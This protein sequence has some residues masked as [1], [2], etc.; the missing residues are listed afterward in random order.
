MLCARLLRAGGEQGRLG[1]WADGAVDGLGRGYGWLL[2]KAF[3]HRLITVLAAAGA[4]GLA[5]FFAG[6]LSSEFL[7]TVDRSQFIVFFE[8]PEGSTLRATKQQEEE[9]QELLKGRDD[10]KHFFSIIG[11]SRGAGP[12][13]VNEGVAFVRLVGRDQRKAHQS[14]IAQQV[15]EQLEQIPF[16]RAYVVESGGTAMG[17]GA[18]IKLVL[19]HP[20]LDVLA[21]RQE[22]LMAWMRKSNLYTGVNSNLKLN[23]PQVDVRPIRDKANDMGVT[24]RAINDAYR[25]LLAE[26]D[27]SEIERGRERYEVIPEIVMRGRMVPEMLGGVY[28][29]TNEGKLVSAGDLID[30]QEGVGPSAV[31]H[32]NRIR[33]AT[34]SASAPPGVSL[35]QAV[36]SLEQRLQGSMAE[37][38][39]YA[40]SGRTQDFQESFRNLLLTIGLAVLFIYLVLSAQFESFIQPLIILVALPLAGVGAFAA[41]WAFDMPLGIVSFIGLIMLAGMATKN[42]ILMIDYSNVLVARGMSRRDA[43]REA[44]GVRFRPVVMTTVS[45]VLGITPIALGFGSGGEARSPMGVAVAFGLLATTILT[46]V[47]L[48]VVY[49]LVNEGVEKLRD[50]FGDRDESEG[51]Q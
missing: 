13:K 43:A 23:K 2:D 8:M 5:V 28:V 39:D 40:F 27:I 16:G 10:V 9:I 3:G 6:Q 44:A 20:E 14:V 38:M 49:T 12:G 34:I 47:F 18:E 50:R 21:R 48:P 36:S 42:A 29:R 25:F 35:G 24:V 26:P 22:N 37:R 1:R 46:L 45:T 41:L 15:R 33:S 31:H 30:L 17:S 51:D 7:P 4:L 32:Y 19:Q 11:L